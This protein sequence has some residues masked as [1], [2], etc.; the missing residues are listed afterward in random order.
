MDE[1][2]SYTLA[3]WDSPTPKLELK[4]RHPLPDDNGH[5]LRA[6][7]ASADLVLSTHKHVWLFD[8]DKGEFRPHPDLHERPAVKTVEP[9]PQTGRLVVVQAK[10]PNWWTDAI[11]LLHPA[12]E[13]RLEGEKIY[14]VRWLIGT[15]GAAGE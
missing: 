8:R 3:A 10:K 2:C 6:M 14:K 9:H 11:T 7:P 4:S 15:E 13:C 5:D 12:G 1:L